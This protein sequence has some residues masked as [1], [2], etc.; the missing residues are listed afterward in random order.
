MPST[1]RLL[2]GPI[3]ARGNRATIDEEG[4]QVAVSV[5]EHE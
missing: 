5:Q 1:V 4:G 3:G 2:R